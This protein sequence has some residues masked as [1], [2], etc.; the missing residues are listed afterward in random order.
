MSLSSVKRPLWR[1]SYRYKLAKEPKELILVPCDCG[2]SA[3]KVIG[4]ALTGYCTLL[5]AV[6][7][8]PA[9]RHTM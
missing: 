6:Y 7:Q 3:R 1:P 2:I 4:L 9:A 8:A 5:A